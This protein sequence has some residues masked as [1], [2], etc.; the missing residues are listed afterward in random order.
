MNHVFVETNWVVDLYAPAHHRK[1]EAVR[2][3]ERARNREILLHMPA[4]CLREA[5]H[6]LSQRFKPKGDDLKAFRRWALA[7]SRPH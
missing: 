5:A 6:V 7:P 4:I 2:L 3:A 1:N